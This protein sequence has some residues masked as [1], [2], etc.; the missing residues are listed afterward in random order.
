MSTA[1]NGV[2]LFQGVGSVAGHISSISYWQF[3]KKCGRHLPLLQCLLCSESP[4]IYILLSFCSINDLLFL[5]MK[6]NFD[7]ISC[8]QFCTHTH[9]DHPPGSFSCLPYCM[10]T[11]VH[12]SNM[13]C[14][15]GASPNHSNTLTQYF[16]V[17][18]ASCCKQSTHQYMH[19]IPYSEISSKCCVV[20]F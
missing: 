19:N 1:R 13:G 17:L 9:A 12:R 7:L 5:K 11:T 10:T 15:L 20:D 6:L 14:Y 2:S 3:I 8:L 18:L 4:C 16:Q